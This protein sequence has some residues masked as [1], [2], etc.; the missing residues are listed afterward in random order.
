MRFELRVI[1]VLR[2]FVSAVRG[3]ITNAILLCPIF[4]NARKDKKGVSFN[5][6]A[7]IKTLQGLFGSSSSYMII[8]RKKMAFLREILSLLILGLINIKGA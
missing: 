5:W 1:D 4:H 6:N 3:L 7:L 2:L 8:D